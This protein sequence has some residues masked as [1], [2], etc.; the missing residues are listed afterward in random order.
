MTILAGLPNSSRVAETRQDSKYHGAFEETPSFNVLVLSAIGLS[1]RHIG[2][3]VQLHPSLQLLANISINQNG[4]H[5]AIGPGEET[6]VSFK[7]TTVRVSG[8]FFC[9]SMI[10]F[11][12][13]G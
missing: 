8:E 4:S 5:I 10:V 6:V 9:C 12:H 2:S 3:T 13:H 7:G 11:K 1:H